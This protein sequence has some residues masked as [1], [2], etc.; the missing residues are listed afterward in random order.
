MNIRQA[1]SVVSSPAFPLISEGMNF[2]VQEGLHCGNEHILHET[3]QA[4]WAEE[5]GEVLGVIVFRYKVAS[6]AI[7]I[8]LSYVEPSSRRNGLYTR[9]MN[10]LVARAEEQSIV[11]ILSTVSTVNA[12]MI[13]LMQ[14]MGRPPTAVLY[15]LKV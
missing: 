1:A 15:E 14:K 13:K 11:R 9:L 5:D 4:I 12:A 10:A 7:Q 8:V 3:D 2:L 6:S